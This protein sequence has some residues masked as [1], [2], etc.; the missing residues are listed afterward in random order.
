[1]IGRFN[2]RGQTYEGI[3]PLFI[4]SDIYA[5]A[6][7]VLQGHNRPKYSKHDLAF[8]G[9][10]MCA[11]DNCAVPAELK[12]NKYVYYRCT[13]YRG[14]CALPRFESR[15]L[16][17]D[18]DTCS[19][20]CASPKKLCRAS[21]HPCKRVHVQALN[22]AAQE[23]VRLERDLATLRSHMD[24]AYTDKL[25]G[26]IT[27]GFWQR[28]QADWQTDE[29]RIK[30]LISG[31]NEDKCEER[32]LD[33]H[34]ILELAQ[35]AYSLYVTRKPAEQAELLKKVLLNCS[36]DGVSLYPTY[37]KPFDI[38]VKRAKSKK[39]SGRRDSN[40]RPSAPKE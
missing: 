37:K 32:L 6:Q 33:V 36:I 16:R 25:D 28:K 18:W 20:T 2:L 40:P 27:E 3:Q 38:I 34:G 11:H 23:R 39:W 5:Q 15:K 7:S 31:L 24:A 21:N 29:L 19:R 12:K 1:V 17:I 35:D 26:T 4:N 8:K 10:L 9:M 13:G 14:K 22:Q 30:S